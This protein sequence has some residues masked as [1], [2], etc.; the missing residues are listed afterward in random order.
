[1]ASITIA[2]VLG[3]CS[4]SICHTTPAVSPIGPNS[5]LSEIDLVPAGLSRIT[6]E[7]SAA[8]RSNWS[9]ASEDTGL[10]GPPD[11]R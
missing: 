2:K 8:R 5:G 4:E 7:F 9:K 11:F 1:M 3:P 6:A 10:T